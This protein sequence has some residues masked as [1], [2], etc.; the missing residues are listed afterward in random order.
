MKKYS[1][2]LI[3]REMQI[4]TIMKY[5]FTSIRMAIIQKTSDNK[6]WRGIKL[7]LSGWSTKDRRPHELESTSE[8]AKREELKKTTPL[9]C[10]W[11]PGLIPELSI[12]RYNPKQHTVGSQVQE[13]PVPRTC[14]AMEWPTRGMSEEHCEDPEN[15]TGTETTEVGRDLE[16]KLKLIKL[17][18]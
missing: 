18:T 9:S 5:H 12:C 7:L 2:L 14:M 4:K 3:I 8:I 13:R 16:S 1:I 6:H 10:L 11:A 17:I 15:T